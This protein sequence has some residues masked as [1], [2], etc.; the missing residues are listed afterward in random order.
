MT[1]RIALQR[2]SQYRYLVEETEAHVLSRDEFFSLSII[3]SNARRR[4]LPFLPPSSLPSSPLLV[5]QRRHYAKHQFG[6]S[7]LE[8]SYPAA[9]VAA[10][11]GAPPPEPTLVSMSLTF[12]P[13]SALANRV[14]QM[15]SSST[16][17]ALVKERILSACIAVSLLWCQGEREPYGDLLVII[18][19]DESLFRDKLTWTFSCVRFKAYSVCAESQSQRVLVCL[20]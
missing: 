17:A 16:F 10:A 7:G 6:R 13:S 18:G 12:L 2:I 14:A 11:A 20:Q 1:S 3:C 19:K 5:R 4:T 15:G 8:V 9:G